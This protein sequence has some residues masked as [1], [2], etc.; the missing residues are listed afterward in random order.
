MDISVIVCSYNRCEHLRKLLKSLNEQAVPDEL[1]WEILVVDNNSS[2]DTARTVEEMSGR[3]E[4]I[5]HYIFEGR[6]GKSFALNAG[7]K[8]A[9]GNILAFTDDDAVLPRDWVRR[10]AEEFG[11]DAQLAGLG[12]R[13]ELLDDG[14]NAIATRRGKLALTL[15]VAHFPADHIPIIGCNMAIRREVF[16]AVGFFDARLGP[17]AKGGVGEDLDYLYRACKAGF[18]FAY[19][20]EVVVFH[21]HG[22]RT[23]VEVNRI[24]KRY[25]VGRGGFYW[26]H[27]RG[28][29]WNVAKLAMWE[30]HGVLRRALRAGFSGARMLKE[31]SVLRD[32][33][34]GAFALA[35]QRRPDDIA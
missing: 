1:G 4:K 23:D 12:G 17:G 5:F 21:D 11:K 9:H 29:D 16:D 25:I 22:R 35:V 24:K 33:M 18:K 20:P 34:L 14:D 6:Q 30:I 19:L 8:A 26:K 31:L 28:G 32:L 15:S 3:N 2:D 7:V 27:V 10:I 13:V